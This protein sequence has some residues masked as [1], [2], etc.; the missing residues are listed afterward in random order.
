MSQAV[1]MGALGKARTC[2]HLLAIELACRVLNKVFNRDKILSLTNVGAKDFHQAV[3][4]C[5]GLLK[6]SFTTTAAIDVLSVQFG[7]ERKE[8]TLKLLEMYREQY[9]HKLD[10]ARQSLI[11]LSSPEYQAA[12]FIVV[13][14]KAKQRVDKKR[15]CEVCDISTSLVQNI[16]DDLEK[17][18]H[19]NRV[20]SSS[21]C[22]DGD[23]G[24][25]DPK[26]TATA[27][28]SRSKGHRQL[29]KASG[30]SSGTSSGSNS[31]SNRIIAKAKATDAWL[32][33][34]RSNVNNKE[35]DRSSAQRKGREGGCSSHYPPD[36]GSGGYNYPLDGGRE[37][38][39]G[40][41]G[42]VDPVL[43][44]LDR[45]TA[46]ASSSSSSSSSLSSHGA[47][48]R[49]GAG[50]APKT[51]AMM[52]TMMA[53]KPDKYEV[54]RAQEAVREAEEREQ[55]REAEEKKRKRFASWKEGLLKKRKTQQQQQQQ[56]VQHTPPRS[57]D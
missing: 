56:Q 23:G 40:S 36:G 3:Q 6:L 12:A 24:G 34:N 14:K 50:A 11:D 46:P 49:A 57:I 5:K 33:S 13:A 21:T 17:V 26:A 54:A 41:S 38:N 45:L 7:V 20:S 47:G 31:G 9:V 15:V 35:N 53:R 16:I 25:G 48:A 39:E 27:T 19:A 37:G 8:P 42:A 52:M 22:G 10:K 28:A 44:V 51:M 30:T 55:L 32:H 18:I 4:N 2:K 1:P 29:L 43:T